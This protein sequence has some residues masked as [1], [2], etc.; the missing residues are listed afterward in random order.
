MLPQGS[1]VVAMVSG[2]ADSMALLHLLVSGELGD[3]L[4]VSVLHVNHLLR[5]A[6]ADADE[7]YVVAECARLGV[8]CRAVRFDVAGYAETAGLNL[9]D[10]GRIVRYRFAAEEADARALAVSAAPSGARIAVAHTLDDRIETFV[11]RLLSGAGMGGLAS[12]RPVRDRIVRPLSDVPRPQIRS[13][14][15]ECGHSWREDVSNLDTSRTRARI[16]HEVLPVLLEAEPA[17]HT[18]LART[19]RILTDE[20]ALLA[21]MAEAFVR[22]F[23]T[24]EAREGEVS[25]DRAMLCTLT[26]AMRRR[27]VRAALERTFPEVSRLDFAHVEAVVS[28]LQDDAFARDL[29]GGLRAFTEYGRMTVSQ[30]GEGCPPV[31]P[32]LLPLPGSVDLGHTGVLF[33]EFV[34]PEDHEGDA[35]SVVVDVGE[36]E[37]L[38]VGPVVAGERMQPLGMQGT[39]KLSDLLI[40]AKVPR[41]DRPSVPVVRDGKRVV[42]LAGVRQSEEYRVGPGTLRAVRLTLQADR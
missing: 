22:D 9:E 7:A 8:S 34:S 31:A 15:E 21:E 1:T 14:L 23:T 2:G 41:R 6:D 25:L 26:P 20:D 32:S 36:A 30:H 33:A 12:I 18:T 37:T 42:W 3:G 39:K 13:W 24:A 11:S 10:A 27:T 19:M 29:T 4:D 17:L 40:D 35:S 38:S 5:G 16:R 28:G